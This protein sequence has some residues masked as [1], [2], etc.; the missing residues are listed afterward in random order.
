MIDC[1]L[2]NKVEDYTTNQGN[3][4]DRHASNHGGQLFL[5]S[6]STQSLNFSLFGWFPQWEVFKAS[7]SFITIHLDS[8]TSNVP[9]VSD[10]LISSPGLQSHAHV[11]SATAVSHLHR[12]ALFS[13][14]QSKP[15]SSASYRPFGPPSAIAPVSFAT[16][17]I[18]L[19][20]H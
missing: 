4:K 5:P 18:F 6:S 14:Y 17:D 13:L 3:T 10:I 11:V 19:S 7:F 9:F 1:L 12:H 16:V 8:P 2:P 20:E 15:S